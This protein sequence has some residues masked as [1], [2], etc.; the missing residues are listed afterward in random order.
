MH[1][2]ACRLRCANGQHL[3]HPDVGLALLSLTP[4]MT[5]FS[6]GS[7]NAHKGFLG[8]ASKHLSGLRA[9]GQHRLHEKPPSAFVADLSHATDFVTMR[10]IDVARILHQQDD[11]RRSGLFSRLVQVRLHQGS[12]A[13]IWLV[14]QTIQG[15]GLFPR[16]HLSRQGT[17]GILR[18]VAGRF[19]RASRATQIMQLGTPKGSLGPALGVQQVLRSH[20]SILSLCKMWVRIRA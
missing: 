1:P 3:A 16:V 15:F 11:W 7:G 19:Y 6:I 4:L 5:L 12:K 20:P 9:H 2:H 14:K 13:D 17:Q 8:H 18:Q 10:Q